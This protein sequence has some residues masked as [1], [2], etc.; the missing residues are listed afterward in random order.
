MTAHIYILISSAL[1]SLYTR[2][3]RMIDHAMAQA[4]SRRP[5]TAESRVRSRV[6]HVGFVV[7]K[8]ALEQGFLQVLRVFPV[9]IIP[10]SFS[11][12]IYRLRDEQCVR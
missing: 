5:L 4:V 8:G 9:N 2:V 10:P 3:S 12:L 6:I 7:D 1:H 11:I